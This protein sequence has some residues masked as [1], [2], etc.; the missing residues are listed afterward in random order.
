MNLQMKESR[1]HLALEV[2]GNPMGMW[3]TKEQMEKA[4]ELM[5]QN[6]EKYTDGKGLLQAL[7]DATEEI[8][9]L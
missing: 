6:P 3:V 1:I 2:D 7:L 8:R 5:E 9:Y 4:D